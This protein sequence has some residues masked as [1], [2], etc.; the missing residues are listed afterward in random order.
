M[1]IW[2]GSHYNVIF[3]L[4]QQLGGLPMNITGWTFKS[5]IR[6]K[7]SDEIPMIELTTENGGIV[8]LDALAG[9]IELKIT[10]TQ[11]KD[12]SLGNVVGDIFRTDIVPGPERLFGFRERVRKPVTRP[13]DGGNGGLPGDE[14]DQFV[15][16]EEDDSYLL[17]EDT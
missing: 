15:L 2:Q 9:R 3:N 10:A 11:N 4:E 12:F 8:I 17:L 16:E 6:D 1:T 13:G 5:H 7:N 14:L